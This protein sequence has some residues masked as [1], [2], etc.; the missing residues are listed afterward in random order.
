MAK[1]ILVINAGSSSIKFAGYRDTEAAEPEFLGKGQVEGLRTAPKFIAADANGKLLGEH[2]WSAPVTHATALAHIIRWIEGNVTEVH[3]DA[4]GHRVVFGGAAYTGPTLVDDRVIADIEELVPFFPLHVPHNLAAIRALRDEH[5]QVPQVVCFDNSF[6]RTKP[7][8]AQLY[9]LPRSLTDRGIRRYGFHG[10]SYEYIARRLP[11]LAPAATRVVVAHLGSGA[12]MCAIRDGQSIECTLG[13]SALDGLVM[14]TRVG[15][16]DAGVILFLMQVMDMDAAAIEKLLYKQSGL[17]G[18]SGIS[19]D[20]RDLL[21]SA[22]P[23][24]EEAVELFVYQIVKQLGALAAAL[25]GID[26]LVFTAG[27]GEH[28]AP[29]RERVCRKAEWLGIRL[30]PAANEAH[31]PR[32][33]TRDSPVS[34][35]V[36][37]TDEERMIAIHTKEA[38]ATSR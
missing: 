21:V 8:V 38:V 12:S 10:L 22:E 9:A 6:H 33:S 1:G 20:M 15:P 32:I 26:A 34:S 3:V 23:S 19:N 25:Q 30:D 29:I 24:A 11:D 2:R 5:P 31:G 37:P 13:F 18:V 28:A 4:V 17:L 35:W 7:R 16:L 14:G 36:I 27:I